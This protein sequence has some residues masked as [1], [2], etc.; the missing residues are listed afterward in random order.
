MK[1]NKVTFFALLVLL[2]PVY[3]WAQSSIP[4][5]DGARS[6]FDGHSVL[7]IFA[8]G[9]LWKYLPALKN[10][11]NELIPWLGFIGY[12]LTSLVG[13]SAPGTALGSLANVAT[14][15]VAHQSLLTTLTHAAS[16][17][18]GAFGLFESLGRPLLKMLAVK[19]P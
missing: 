11:T 9:L 8:F 14:G 15:T 5:P 13:A 1:T 2:V 10:W 7:I 4:S 17:V 18:V 3:A 19:K 12:V 6:W 16:N